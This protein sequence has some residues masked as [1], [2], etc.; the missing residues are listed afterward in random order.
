MASCDLAIS[1][2][3]LHRKDMQEACSL[4]TRECLAYGLPLVLPY[5]DSDLERLDCDFLLKIPNKEDNIHTHGQAI[6][7]FAYR[8][9]GRRAERAAIAS[10]DQVAKEKA[11]IRFFE[12]ILSN[13]RA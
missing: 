7:D 11:R 10:I 8:M 3:A 6:H 2:L 12:E 9:R 13:R 4:K 1:T 5:R